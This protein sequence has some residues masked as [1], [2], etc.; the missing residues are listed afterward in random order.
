MK[1][2]IY[3][4]LFF[5][6]VSSFS[7]AKGHPDPE[8]EHE[9]SKSASKG[10]K[11]TTL[12]PKYALQKP[13]G[14]P[15]EFQESWGYVTMS[16][17]D[18]YNEDLPITDVCFFAADFNCYGELIDIPKRSKLKL[19]E[20]ARSH[21]VAIC[22][23]KSLTHF[24]LD[25]SIPVRN[26][27]IKDLVKAAKDFDGLQLDFELVPA[28]DGPNFMKFCVD[29]KSALEKTYGKDNKMYTICVPARMRL[30]TDDIYPYAELAKIFDRIFVMAYDEHWSTSKPGPIASMDWCEK[31]VDY[32]AS[33]VPPEKLIM[34]I[35]FYGRTWAKDTV[36][37]AWYFSG[38]NRIMT[39]NRVKEVKY[40]N[41]IP[42][43]DYTALVQIK[44]YFN[45]AYSAV[46]LCRLYESKNVS[47]IGF[48]RIG[49]EDPDFW[50]WLVLK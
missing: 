30:L 20:N 16:R 21:M 22:D 39:E 34:G 13:A 32:A 2:I 17:S 28:K 6:C 8:V 29:L 3:L 5:V 35:P 23:S 25:P 37:G 46:Q 33:T 40:E 45:D 36:A 44:G 14:S 43:F 4:A 38:A 18:E 47:N 15:V 31:I 19:P 49:Q 27:A 9:I 41:D 48:W 42:T 12:K 24:V 1:R 11:T 7:F 10:K 26:Q 50:E